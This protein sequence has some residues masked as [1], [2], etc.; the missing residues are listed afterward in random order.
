M[1]WGTRKRGGGDCGNFRCWGVCRGPEHESR[2]REIRPRRR[3]REG[4]PR[5]YLR[6]QPRRGI[7][8]SINPIGPLLPRL[9]SPTCVVQGVPSSLTCSE[10][11]AHRAVGLNLRDRGDPARR[12]VPSARAAPGW[13]R[14]TRAPRVCAPP[15]R[16]APR[17]VRGCRRGICPPPEVS[18]WWGSGSRP[19]VRPPRVRAGCHRHSQ[20]LQE[21]PVTRS[22]RSRRPVPSLQARPSLPFTLLLP[23]PLPLGPSGRT[24]SV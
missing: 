11:R 10:R 18:S 12:E 15:R 20:A 16:C 13:A 8:T 17:R 5:P 23:P 1:G 9:A 24:S 6:V 2:V 21:K 3:G 7:N 14:G 4:S 19:R 22:L